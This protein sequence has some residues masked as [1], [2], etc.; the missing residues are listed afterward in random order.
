[1]KST[2]LLT[3]FLYLSLVP[4]REKQFYFRPL[5]DDGSGIP[6]FGKQPVG[7]NK[8]SQII[9][10]MCK[11]AGIEGRKSADQGAHWPSFT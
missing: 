6:K 8:L 4:S 2:A 7:Q 5:A 10:V 9:P 11:A 3:F 1:M